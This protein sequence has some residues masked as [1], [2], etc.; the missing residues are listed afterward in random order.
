M[1]N[2]GDKIK[3][4]D[5]DTKK[6]V[7]AEVTRIASNGIRANQEGYGIVAARIEYR[8]IWGRE[9]DKQAIDKTLRGY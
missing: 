3:V 4:F 2:I 6:I 5:P 8:G 1:I 7:N 9:E